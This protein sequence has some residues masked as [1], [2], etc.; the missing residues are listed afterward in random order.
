[1]GR[2]AKSHRGPAAGETPRPSSEHSYVLGLPRSDRSLTADRKKKSGFHHVRLQE[3][4][5]F[6]RNDMEIVADSGPIQDDF[7]APASSPSMDLAVCTFEPDY[8]RSCP[9]G[10]G[11]GNGRSSWIGRHAYPEGQAPAIRTA[12]A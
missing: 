3:L 11:L 2:H 5:Q 7:K 1:M 10:V 9:F 6:T 8:A 12:T 4:C